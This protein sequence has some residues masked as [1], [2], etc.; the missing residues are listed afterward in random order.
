VK[1]GGLPPVCL[2]FLFPKKRKLRK[3]QEKNQEKPLSLTPFIPVPTEQL[4][5]LKN[6][7]SDKKEGFIYRL[8]LIT[9]IRRGE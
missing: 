1:I 2:V 8:F 6:Q 4:I 9:E 5:F 3:R 7:D